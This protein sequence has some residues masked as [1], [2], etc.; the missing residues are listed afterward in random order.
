MPHPHPHPQPL[1]AGGVW[2]QRVLADIRR[3][4]A[5]KHKGNAAKCNIEA[6]KLDLASLASVRAF[7]DK[8][9]A[10][11]RPLHVLMNNGTSGLAPAH[12]IP[13]H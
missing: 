7:A 4:C 1:T 13:V 3:S 12:C 8:F 9:I 11:R 10:S 5:D 6:W 2:L